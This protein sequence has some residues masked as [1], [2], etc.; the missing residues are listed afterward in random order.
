MSILY[1]KKLLIL[2]LLLTFCILAL[3]IVA[4]IKVAILLFLWLLTFIKITKKELFIFL[5]INSIF[6]LSDIGA[7]KNGFFSFNEHDI[8]VLPY[9]ELFMWGFYL[10]HAHRM[11]AGPYPKKSEKKVFILA[12]LFTLTFILNPPG[13]GVLLLSGFI[14]LIS[15][16]YFHNKADVR[17]ILYLIVIG[18]IVE[19]IGLKYNLWQYSTNNYFLIIT[20]IMIMWGASGL[21]F[22]RLAGPYIDNRNAV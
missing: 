4:G 14:L 21:Y 11:L 20:Q 6:I 3:P 19:W 1:K 12:L 10:L 8:G 18:L 15:L 5:A 2:Q 13:H 9:Y 7:I 17:Y 16:Y 22:R